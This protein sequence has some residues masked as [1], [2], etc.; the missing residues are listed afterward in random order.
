MYVDNL[1]SVAS[2]LISTDGGLGSGN[3]LVLSEFRSAKTWW[4]GLLDL[5]AHT[6]MPREHIGLSPQFHIR[7]HSTMGP[8]AHVAFHHSTAAM[9]ETFPV[10]KAINDVFLWCR[11][12]FI[13]SDER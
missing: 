7:H 1:P 13:M 6:A 11:F 10:H 12:G 9:P 5:P 4:G 3:K 8:Q 2:L